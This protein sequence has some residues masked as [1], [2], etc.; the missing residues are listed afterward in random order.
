MWPRGAPA[1]TAEARDHKEVLA[2]EALAQ[3]L[4][5]DRLELM[6]R[7]VTSAEEALAS[8]EAKI[9]LE[10]DQKVPEVRQSLVVEYCRKLGLQE[11]R[12]KQRQAE[13]QG[14]A[15]AI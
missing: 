2:L 10:V 12:F 11:T 9:Q 8:R 5:R 1:D 6:E 14:K 13:L 15:D 7:Q 4:E 3:S